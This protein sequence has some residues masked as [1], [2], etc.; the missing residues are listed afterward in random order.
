MFEVGRWYTVWLI[1]DGDEGYLDYKVLAYESPLL[2]L[3]SR[4]GPDLIVNTSSPMFV[5]AH[6]SRFQDD[7]RNEPSAI[8][9]LKMFDS[10]PPKTA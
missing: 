10:D 4:H 6:L 5:R 8:G 9:V 3:G 7:D 2:R 1:E